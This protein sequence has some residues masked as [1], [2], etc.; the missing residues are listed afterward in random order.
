MDFFFLQPAQSGP[1]QTL[2]APLAAI[3]TAA[4]PPL[5]DTF[6]ETG[7]KDKLFRSK[8]ARVRSFKFNKLISPNQRAT[9]SITINAKTT[10]FVQNKHSQI[11]S[12]LPLRV[13]H[14]LLGTIHTSLVVFALLLR[15]R[16]QN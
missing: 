4:I 14:F 11:P 13:K 9:Y 5:S 15:G 8:S 6:N 3:T 7:E 10:Y 16:Y 12:Q 2:Q 1:P